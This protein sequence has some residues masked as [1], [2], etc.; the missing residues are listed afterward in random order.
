[1]FGSALEVLIHTPTLA[2]P[3]MAGAVTLDDA[4]TVALAWDEQGLTIPEEEKTPQPVWPMLHRPHLIAAIADLNGLRARLDATDLR[5]PAIDRVIA[6]MEPS[7]HSLPITGSTSTRDSLTETDRGPRQIETDSW[8]GKTE[9]S[10]TDQPDSAGMAR[11]GTARNHEARHGTTRQASH[12]GSRRVKVGV[13]SHDTTES[14]EP[15]A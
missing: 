13:A 9:Q 3:T 2:I 7:P 15:H 10:E 4:R 14:G 8:R 1:M 11:P 5:L 12:G 6:A